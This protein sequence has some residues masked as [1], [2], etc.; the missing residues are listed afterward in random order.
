MLTWVKHP[1]AF[2]CLAGFSSSMANRKK[3][4]DAGRL[5]GSSLRTAE[6]W[7]GIEVRIPTGY[8]NETGFH[9]GLEFI[10]SLLEPLLKDQPVIL[11]P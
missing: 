7:A 3:F 4:E 6:L 5:G 11:P 1:M 9:Y 10:S 8:Q 2:A